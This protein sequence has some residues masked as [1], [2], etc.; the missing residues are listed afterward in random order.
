ME[1]PLFLKVII[2]TLKP[3]KYK[4][5]T[6]RSYTKTIL[7]IALILFFY[8]LIITVINIPQYK[9][10][11][12]GANNKFGNVTEFSLDINIKTNGPVIASQHPL[13]VIDTSSNGTLKG[14]SALITSS[15]IH[16]KIL[17]WDEVFNYNHVD[18]LNHMDKV[19]KS[20]L[21]LLCIFV[22]TL[23][24]LAYL[25]VF[26]KYLIIASVLGILG[27]VFLLIL[28]RNNTFGESFKTAVYAL[29]IYLIGNIIGEIIGVNFL[30]LVFY[31]IFFVIALLLLGES[32]EDYDIER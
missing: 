27:F 25:F 21:F 3:Q 18:L 7:Y 10:M 24:I 5:I 20:T 8:L 1:T 13:I 19:R 12:T 32:R 4:G 11:L 31:L 30:G 23:F 2:D 28:K 22:P 14:E 6:Q 26:L 16:K 17:W 29:T 9:Q 15:E